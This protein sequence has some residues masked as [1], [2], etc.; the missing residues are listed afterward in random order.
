M[1]A[2]LT[3]AALAAT[4]VASQAASVS[5]SFSNLLQTTEI[6]QTG[7]LGLFD[8]GLGTL[9]GALLTV[10]GEA[11]MEFTGYN[12]A[13]QSQ[14]ARLTS[15]VELSWSSSL[16]ALS[17]LLTDTINLSATSGPQTYAVGETKSFGPLTDTGSYSKNLSAILASL[18][19]PGGGTFGVSCNSLSGL[20]VQGGGGNIDTTQATQAACGA[21]I[22]YTYDEAPPPAVPEPGS[23][24]LMG[25]ALAGLAVSRRRK[26]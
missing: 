9:T 1:K 7:T 22:A 20:A 10:N 2:I 5:Y 24:A 12:K 21:N 14:T 17:S 3:A 19:A 16:A 18:Q 23:L 15:S 8:S 6:S 4:A 25:L 13:S 26:A 11:V